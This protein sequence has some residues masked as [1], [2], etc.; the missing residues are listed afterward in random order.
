VIWGTFPFVLIMIGFAI[1]LILVP[2]I[3]LWLPRSM[4]G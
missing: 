1:L 4:S 2:D 3:A